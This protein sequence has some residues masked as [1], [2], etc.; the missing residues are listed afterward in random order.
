MVAA[1]E[2]YELR[3]RMVGEESFREVEKAIMLHSVDSCW[4]AHLY[5]MEALKEGVGLVGV[6]GKNPLIE[7]K[8]GA[9]D[10]FES[11]ISRVNQESLRALF[12]L[13]FDPQVSPL[14]RPARA[15]RLNPIHRE[16]TNLG[17]RG[18]APAAGDDMPL[19]K[20][21]QADSARD[22]FS[23][24]GGGSGGEAAA[25]TPARVGPKVGRNAPCPCGSGKKYKRCHGRDE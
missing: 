9:F 4:Q 15:D 18:A 8:K 14:D 23:G 13:R 21:P 6:G 17:F 16:A 7:Y 19:G 20:P 22:Q 3:L 25:R 1:V 11:L 12:R 2:A 5:E 24:S 10:M